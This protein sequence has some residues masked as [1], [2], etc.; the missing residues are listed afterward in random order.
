MDYCTSLNLCKEIPRRS[1]QS[2]AA[3]RS[4]GPCATAVR[5]SHLYT[6]STR[7]AHLGCQTS[8]LAL[9]FKTQSWKTSDDSDNLL[10]QTHNMCTKGASRRHTSPH[11][12]WITAVN[13]HTTD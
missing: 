12:P 6:H 3:C 10:G 8:V 11:I 13:F 1:D 2:W 5:G 4:S 7:D 9:I